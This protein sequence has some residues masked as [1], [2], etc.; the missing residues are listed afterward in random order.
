VP[1]VPCEKVRE[2]VLRRDANRVEVRGL[3]S[4]R[5]ARMASRKRA[6]GEKGKK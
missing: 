6:L 3:I 2:E 5:K 4:F 1:C